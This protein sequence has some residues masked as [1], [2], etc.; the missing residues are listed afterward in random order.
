MD[1]EI[2]FAHW[3]IGM[4]VLNFRD[5]IAISDLEDDRNSQRCQEDVADAGA[6]GPLR[7]RDAAESVALLLNAPRAHI[8]LRR[9]KA[10][11]ETIPNI[12]S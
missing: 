10:G 2:G 8:P 1:V 11:R 9:R 12:G 5:T 3:E 7:V 4:R 6:I